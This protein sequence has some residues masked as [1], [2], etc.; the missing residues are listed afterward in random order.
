MD[1]LAQEK[2][3]LP[4]VLGV[5]NFLRKLVYHTEQTR[6]RLRS[7][8]RTALANMHRFH[9]ESGEERAELFLF[10]QYQRW[11]LSSSSDSWWN[12]VTSKR[13][14][15]SFRLQLMAICCNRRVEVK[16]VHLI[17]HFFSCSEHALIVAHHT[18]WFKNVLVR[19]M[20]STWSPMCAS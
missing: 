1:K 17:R 4:N 14:W 2:L 7:D 11:Y 13:W 10:Q 3:L 5:F 8:F 9:R 6:L 15:S 12:W 16:T 20:P 18:A 19:V